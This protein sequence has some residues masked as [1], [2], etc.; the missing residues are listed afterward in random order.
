MEY[1]VPLEYLLEAFRQVKEIT[2]RLDRPITFP[3]EVRVLGADEI[4]LSPAYGRKSGY[5]AVHVYR[6]TP[7]DPYFQLVEN[8]MKKFDGR[9]HWGKVHSRTSRELSL[10]Y[11]Q[12]DNFQSVLAEL[13]PD[14]HFSTPYLDRV[15]RDPA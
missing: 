11:P 14:G 7:I 3:I 4:P 6:G 9:P 2:N 15:L 13:D 8:I 10:L 12:W 5:I 1:A